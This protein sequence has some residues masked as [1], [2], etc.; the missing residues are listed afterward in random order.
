MQLNPLENFTIFRQIGDHTDANRD[1]YYVRATVREAYTS[2]KIADVA[3]TNKGNGEYYANWTAPADNTPDGIWIVITTSVFTNSSYTTKST[4]YSDV[5][6]TYL[7]ADRKTKGSG[8]GGVFVDY[9]RIKKMIKDEIAAIKIPKAPKIPKTD[10]S[11]IIGALEGITEGFKEMYA[12][13]DKPPV[14][15]PKQEKIDYTKIEKSNK[16]LLKPVL[17]ELSTKLTDAFQ[18]MKDWQ[19]KKEI[20][21]NVALN[22]EDLTNVAQEFD[23]IKKMILILNEK[24]K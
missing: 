21:I 2:K 11:E 9:D 19:D 7:V 10:F 22:K 14:K 24:I 16:E 12:K 17:S 6:D 18:E 20:S 1:S 23:T 4:L 5:A 15:I 3:L 13:L 8:G